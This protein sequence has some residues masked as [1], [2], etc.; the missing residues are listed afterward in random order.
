MANSFYFISWLLL[1]FKA[2]WLLKTL[3][4]CWDSME[5]KKC[6]DYLA[7]SYMDIGKV[8]SSIYQVDVMLILRLLTLPLKSLSAS[9]TGTGDSNHNNCCFLFLGSA[10]KLVYYFT[11][12]LLYWPGPAKLFPKNVNPYLYTPLM[13]AFATVN[14]KI[15]SY[16]WNDSD[17]LYS[18]FQALKEWSVGIES[19]VSGRQGGIME[20]PSSAP[21]HS[22]QHKFLRGK[23]LCRQFVPEKNMH[24]FDCYGK[25]I[26]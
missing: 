6:H 13:Y 18:Q 22:Y 11:N 4:S 19:T 12:W 21:V 10:Y 2:F 20:S 3:R 8:C 17:V 9:E 5:K 15:A 25:N 23:V 14:D 7:R 26:T 24:I 1:I 16:Q